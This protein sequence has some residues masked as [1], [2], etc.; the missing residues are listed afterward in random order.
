M[1]IA[2]SDWKVLCALKPIALDRFCAKVLEECAAIILDSR[3]TP[4]ER[5]LAVYELMR[6]R[7]R[8]L[9]DAFDDLRRSTAFIRLAHIRG[10]GL[11]TDDEFA[12]FSADTRD[13]VRL[14][15]GR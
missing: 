7:D 5:Y 8:T 4:H 12:R 10:L 11:I 14:I 3:G 2:E 13:A 15:L 1:N 9:G 6:A